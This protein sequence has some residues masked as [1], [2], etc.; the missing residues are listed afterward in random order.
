MIMRVR[1][2]ADIFN[3]SNEST[4]VWI[5]ELSAIPRQGDTIF[6][7]DGWG[8]SRV[9]RVYWELADNEAELHIDDSTGEYQKYFAKHPIKEEK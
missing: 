9:T 5:G 7:L 8:G 3:I 6:I 4:L 1:V 2:Y